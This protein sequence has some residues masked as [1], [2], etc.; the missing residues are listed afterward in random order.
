MNK[1]RVI[2]VILLKNGR[3]VQSKNFN[4]HQVLGTPSVIVGRL[5]N[6]FSDELIFL[7]ISR[8]KTYDLNRNDLNFS[9]HNNIFSIIKEISKKCFMPLN[10]GGG[11]LNLEDIEKRLSSGADK[12]TINSHAIKNPKFVEIAAKE[13]GAQCIVISIDVKKESKIWRAYTN[14]GKIKNDDVLK[15]SKE[16]ENSGA[17]EILIN[18]IDNDG[19]GKGFDIELN[20]KIV[21]LLNIPVVCLGGAG[22]WK[23]LAECIDECNPSGVAASNIFQYVENSVYKAHKYLYQNDFNVR[24]NDLETI[25]LAGDE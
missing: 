18:S 21:K 5:S 22:E 1:T 8:E 25:I 13:F 6:W 12:V 23:H 14:C 20:K 24:K 3:I 9:N 15:V 10:V 16:M 11:I 19:A 7:D 17:G 2:P 4:R